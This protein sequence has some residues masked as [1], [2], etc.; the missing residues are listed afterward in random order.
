[1]LLTVAGDAKKKKERDRFEK[2]G[3]HREKVK[4]DDHLKLKI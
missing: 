4:S 2:D 3:H 1:V